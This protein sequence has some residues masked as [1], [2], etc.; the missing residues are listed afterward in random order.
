MQ[1]RAGSVVG[2][3]WWVDGACG[4]W[5][6]WCGARVIV[7]SPSLVECGRALE[8][9]CAKL[10][11]G[12]RARRVGASRVTVGTIAFFEESTDFFRALTLHAEDSPRLPCLSTKCLLIMQDHGPVC[13]LLLAFLSSI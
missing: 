1:Y 10:P 4:D 11:G 13:S 8:I 3:I 12:G 7:G 9:R 5:R 6:W 2:G